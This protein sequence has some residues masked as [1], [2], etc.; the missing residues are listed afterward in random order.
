MIYS[1]NIYHDLLLCPGVEL[2]YLRVQNL[3]RSIVR[4]IVVSKGGLQGWI[5]PYC[6][7]IQTHSDT[8]RWIDFRPERLLVTAAM[9]FY[10][11][12]NVVQTIFGISRRICFGYH[13]IHRF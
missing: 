7:H 9:A 12:F 3:V 5:A 10:I 6:T 13:E 11:A 4:S 8:R 2:R 1:Y